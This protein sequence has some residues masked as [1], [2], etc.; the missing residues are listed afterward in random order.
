MLETAKRNVITMQEMNYKEM[1]QQVPAKQKPVLLALA[2]EQ[3]AVN[4]M[5]GSFVKKYG[6]SS[7]SSVQSALK[8]LLK[9]DLITRTEKGYR[10]YDFFF[11]EWL[12]NY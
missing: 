4:A 2:K 1:L 3:L 8:G 7:A 5:S 6:L 11:A 9:K 12:R 10:V